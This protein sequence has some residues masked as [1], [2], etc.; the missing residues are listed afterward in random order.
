MKTNIL[1]LL[2]V[3]FFLL[4]GCQ[5]TVNKPAFEVD[6]LINDLELESLGLDYNEKDLSLYTNDPDKVYFAY[7]GEAVKFKDI[8]ASTDVVKREWFVDNQQLLNQQDGQI[9]VP[10]FNHKFETPGLYRIKLVIDETEMVSKLVRVIDSKNTN[11]EIS[12]ETANESQERDDLI[13]TDIG[14]FRVFDFTVSDPSPAKWQAIVLEDIS[15]TDIEITKRLW[16]FG[17]GTIIPTK[18]NKVKYSYSSAGV[19][20][21][22]MCLNLTNNCKRRRIIV[23]EPTSSDQL[24]VVTQSTKSDKSQSANDLRK[25]SKTRKLVAQE[26]FSKPATNSTPKSVVSEKLEVQNLGFEIPDKMQAGLPVRMKD[27]SFPDDAIN[28]RNW[29]IDGE[30]Q[31]FHQRTINYIFDTPGTYEIKMCLNNK[32]DLCIVK[33]INVYQRQIVEKKPEE[34]VT[35]KSAKSSQDRIITYVPVPPKPTLG[36]MCQSYG[37]TGLQ[38]KYKCT[39]DKEY[40]FGNAIVN[41][42]PA[43]DMELQNAEIYG[44]KDGY[45]DVLLLDEEFVELGR[46]KNVQVLP[47]YST[48]EFADLAF[49]LEK[50][51]KYS[52]LLKPKSGKNKIGLENSAN[53]SV[54][55]YNNS[56]LKIQY[57][58]KAMVIYDL[59]YC[60]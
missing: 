32:L 44:N 16:D 34:G 41:L 29:Y 18:G 20:E 25:E 60:L 13:V 52:L 47:G 14:N 26:D 27:S 35:Q 17:D 24:P 6:F 31:N 58:G 5:K 36:F 30:K 22:K 53:C 57:Q 43:V 38:S 42:E 15:E 28:S 7:V 46:I 9:E 49:T 23:R 50:G 11:P 59:K 3:S 2:L 12:A 39:E 8:S 45:M 56:D 19:Y 51:K 55:A 48:I 21:V 37:R 40:F 4:I 33:K 54:P 1:L 10:S